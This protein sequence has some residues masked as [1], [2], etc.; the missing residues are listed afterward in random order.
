VVIRSFA[1]DAT[2]DIYNGKDSK[3]ARRA[4]PKALWAIA[5]RKLTYLHST[6]DI[7]DLSSP[8]GNQLERL[9]AGRSARWSIRINARYRIVFI[10]QQGDA[11]E[12]WVGDYHDSL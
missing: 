1:D 10:W 4:L 12:V 9:K 2:E 11:K 6:R 8:P 5:R 3:V 7:K